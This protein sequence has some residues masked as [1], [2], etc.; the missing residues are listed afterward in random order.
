VVNAR[1]DLS[2][3]SPKHKKEG[4]EY[5]EKM[6]DERT[7]IDDA[8]AASEKKAKMIKF[9]IIGGVVLVL[10]IV[11]LV[12][13]KKRKRKQEEKESSARARH[14]VEQEALQRQIQDQE[15][16]LVDEMKAQAEVAAEKARTVLARLTALDGPMKGQ[17]FEIKDAQCL[18]GR[19][20]D[21][22][23]LAFPA[24]G[25]DVSISR[26]HAELRISGGSWS[27]T[28]MSDGGMSINQ[29]TIRKGEEYPI[30]SGDSI[31]MGKTWF[32]FEAV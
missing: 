14:L 5:R 20:A 30:Q 18:A 16:R 21:R 12:L 19:D 1:L 3:L 17:R 29:T 31:H 26:V 28:C 10:L 13:G 7:R 27:V 8:Q 11:L 4:A 22:C 23:N 6:S 9:G 32:R 2:S 15:Q 25:A 24:E